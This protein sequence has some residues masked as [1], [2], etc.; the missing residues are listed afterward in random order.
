MPDRISILHISDLHRSKGSPISN[1][2]LISSLISDREKYIGEETP[3]IYSP[4][5]IIV[6]GDIIRGSSNPNS[7]E[8]IKEIEDQYKEADEFLTALADNFLEGEKKRII[9]IPGNHDIDWKYS[10]DS[11]EKLENADVLDSRNIVNWAIL[12]DSLRPQSNT[13]WSWKDLSFYKITRPDIYDKRLEAFSKFYYNFYDGHRSYSLTPSEQ[14]DV[15]DY[16]ELDLSIV[17]FNSCYNNDHLRFVGDIHPDCIS[18]ASLQLRE[19]AKRGRLILGTWHH[20]TKGGPFESNYMDGSVLKNFIDSKISI[21]FHGHQHRMEAIHEYSDIVE[22]KSLIIFSAGTLCGG[23]DELPTG[24]NRQYNIIEF[25]RNVY[26]SKIH[27]TLHVREKSESSSFNNPI[28]IPGRIASRNASSYS[29]EFEDPRNIDITTR[30]LDIETLINEKH[31][32]AAK[33]KL[34]MMD[35]ENGFVR[36]FLLECINETEDHDLAIQKFAHPRSIK[37]AITVLN[38]AIALRQTEL[39]KEIIDNMDITLKQDTSV[40]YLINQAQATLHV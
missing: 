19:L 16:S 6:S 20:N 21:G 36:G 9:V 1:T 38:A 13:R 11:M 28:W 31:F 7:Q 26:D 23:P 4:T 18:K 29:F 8:S 2:A 24:I 12:K 3:K 40:K 33:S 30:F 34:I 15:F 37:E 25:E 22:Q 5:L 39:I 32:D 27:A 14:Y 35:I 17:A 10:K